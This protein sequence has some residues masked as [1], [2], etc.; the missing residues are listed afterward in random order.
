MHP[1]LIA[2]AILLLSIAHGAPVLLA[3][4]FGNRFSYPLDAGRLFLDRRPLFGPSKTI[5]G[6]L[7]SVAMTAAAAPLLDLDM[8]GGALFGA[9]AVLG[10]LF[11]SFV[12]RRLGFAPSS[13]A[14]GLD[15]I[16]E[17]LL[18]VL[19]CRNLLPLSGLD[20]FAAVA[21]FSLGVIFLSPLFHRVGLRNRPF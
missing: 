2:K 5:R 8:A 19:A 14:I 3:K 9:M 17:S 13:Q 11:S 16:P 4:V 20:V 10:D 1:F 12:K 6:V 21:A 18:P 15:Q 7:V